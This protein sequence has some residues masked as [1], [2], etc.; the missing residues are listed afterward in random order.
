MS[1]RMAH[2][3]GLKVGMTTIPQK[4]GH[5]EIWSAIMLPGCFQAA[6]TFCPSSLLP[7]AQPERREAA[8]YSGSTNYGD[9]A[10]FVSNRCHTQSR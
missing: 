9:M 3:D 5:L 7:I 2:K 6:F 10:E 1:R 8:F 4:M